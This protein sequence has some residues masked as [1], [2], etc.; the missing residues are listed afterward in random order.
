MLTTAGTKWEEEKNLRTQCQIKGRLDHPF[1][2]KPK[3]FSP[4]KY[5]LYQDQNDSW[6][7][8]NSQYPHERRKGLEESLSLLLLLFCFP[9]ES[10]SLKKK[11]CLRLASVK[12]IST[13]ASWYSFWHGVWP[14][15]S[16][17]I[18]SLSRRGK[19]TSAL[20]LIW[21]FPTQ[22]TTW[23]NNMLRYWYQCRFEH[24]AK[25]Y[26]NFLKILLGIFF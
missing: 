5:L 11:S 20:C 1:E 14:G 3:R 13:H 15:T 12:S 16:L 22:S 6:W 21:L 2:P 4:A 9:L 10:T 24:I 25:I 7:W 19:E 26:V 18:D 17:Q 23:R 8:Q